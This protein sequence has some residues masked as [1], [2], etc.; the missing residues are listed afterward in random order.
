MISRL[1]TF[2]SATTRCTHKER[3]PRLRSLVLLSCRFQRLLGAISGRDKAERMTRRIGV[4]PRAVEA[5]LMV[6]LRPAHSEHGSLGRV[7][8]VNPKMQV[9]LHRRGRVRPSRRLM[10]RRSLERKVEAWLLPLAYRVPVRIRM[11]HRPPRQAA[12]ELR[13]SGG[14]AAVQG[15]SAQ[16]SDTAH[17]FQPTRRLATASPTLT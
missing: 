13:E 4:D 8:V 16:L 1:L 14:I 10:A 6:E 7:E 12:V 2:E 5:R 9:K 17:N 11:D 15:D 3:C